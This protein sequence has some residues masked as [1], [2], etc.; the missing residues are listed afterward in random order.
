M[1]DDYVE[2]GDEN[3]VDEISEIDASEPEQEVRTPGNKDSRDD[4]S[5]SQTACPPR[6]R[7]KRK[8]IPNV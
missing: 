5:E 8:G 2:S 6:K 7:L 4:A 3:E 1:P